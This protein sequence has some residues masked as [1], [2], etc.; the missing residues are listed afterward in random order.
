[1]SSPTAHRLVTELVTELGNILRGDR[2]FYSVLSGEVLVRCEVVIIIEP[3]HNQ[4]AE[5]GFI[6]DGKLRNH[7]LVPGSKMRILI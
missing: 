4:P 7:C 5:V 2:A 1:M 3:A 6:V